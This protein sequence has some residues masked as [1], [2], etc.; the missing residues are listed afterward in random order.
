MTTPES[1]DGPGTLPSWT[2]QMRLLDGLGER[3]ID[4]W[5]PDG[6]TEAEIQDMNRLV[7]SILSEGYL[8]H[9]YAD[10]KRTAF[11]PHW[12]YAF[13][14][15]GPNPDYVYSTAEVEGGGTYKISGF[16]GTTRFVEITQQ[17][18]MFLAPK[19]IETG[20][21]V[22]GTHDLDDLT[23]GDDGYFS[24]ILSGERPE[25]HDGDWWKLG[26]ETRRLTLRRC[27]CDWRN[28]V[29]A[30]IA[31]QR[32]DDPGED[33][34]PQESARR[35]SELARWIEDMI[36]FDM[37]LIRWYREHHGVNQVLRSKK[38]DTMGG[39]PRQAYYDG[40][41]E[42][43]DDEALIYETELPE[44]VR[45]W[46]VLVG[47]DRFCTVDWVNRQSSLNDHQARIDSDG[48]FRAVI[49]K[50]D[51]GVPNWLDKANYPWG[52]IQMRFFVATD[53]PDP[54]VTKVPFDEIRQRLPADTPVVTPDERRLQ[55][56]DRREAAL[57]RRI[58]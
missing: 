15:G 55:L 52:V 51:P 35:F 22:Q 29:D 17:T 11:M 20:G 44:K 23:L 42:I 40:M 39:L 47:D 3:L 12:N 6:A 19:L 34:S 14:Q 21:T 9:V 4:K 25:G 5:R 53:Y 30:R 45:Y 48:K 41:H 10:P 16:R 2:D 38:I 1:S 8:C 49:S 26:T 27:S 32:L 31:I 24:V 13:N 58:W 57:L 37:Q 46:Q 43:T 33:M 36:D 56:Q 54:V 18:W 28:E 50:R 7:L